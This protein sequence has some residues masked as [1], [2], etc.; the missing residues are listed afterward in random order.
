MQQ[1]D[2]LLEDD[3]IFLTHTIGGKKSVN[4]TEPWI[5]K[6]IFPHGVIPS[7]KQIDKST[8]GIFEKRDFESFGNYY[9]KTLL[10]WNNNFNANWNKIESRFKEPEVFKR[11]MNYYFLSCAA[12]F[13]TGKNDLWHLVYTKPGQVEDYKMYRLP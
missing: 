6:Y 7:M 5:D 11:M 10:N 2:T 13:K 12:S 3:G 1:V 8:E 4:S 9:V